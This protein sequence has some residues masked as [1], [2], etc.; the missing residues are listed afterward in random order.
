[1]EQ[2]QCGTRLLRWRAIMRPYKVSQW[3]PRAERYYYLIRGKYALLLRWLPYLGGYHLVAE[4]DAQDLRRATIT[5]PRRERVPAV[6]RRKTLATTDVAPPAAVAASMILSKLPAIREWL[7]ATEYD[8]H[9]VRQPGAL[10]VTTRD[11]LWHLTLTDPD[12]GARLLVSDKELD[13]ALL[14]LEQLVGVS[15]A[16]WQA[17]PYARPVPKS[18]G[19]K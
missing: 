14:L 6:K 2:A 3:L 1:M 18:K 16:P 10:R 4:Y 19:K 17:D 13:K 8:D 9:T 7:S 12:A 11:A 5:Y 15:D